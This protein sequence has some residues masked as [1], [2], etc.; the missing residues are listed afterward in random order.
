MRILCF[1]VG[2]DVQRRPKRATAEEVEKE[3]PETSRTQRLNGE[4]IQ[5]I[6]GSEIQSRTREC[7]FGRGF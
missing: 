7:T 2:R 1:G 4:N 6:N 3:E 5:Y